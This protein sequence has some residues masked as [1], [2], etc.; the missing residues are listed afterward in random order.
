MKP[1]VNWGTGVIADPTVLQTSPPAL[2]LPRHNI[3]IAGVYAE[4]R[5]SIVV[6]SYELL[7]AQKIAEKITYCDLI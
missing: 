4:R 1:S 7:F 2:P 6:L 3:G 5:M